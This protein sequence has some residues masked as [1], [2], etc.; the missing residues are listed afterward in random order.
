[1]SSLA[2]PL[3]HTLGADPPNPSPRLQFDQLT[4][5]DIAPLRNPSTGKFDIQWDATGN[6]L[7]DDTQEHA[8]LS[9]MLGRKAQ[10]WADQTGVRGSYLYVV[11][12]D[13]KA[14]PSKMQGYVVDALQPLIDNRTILAPQGQQTVAVTA[15]RVKPGRIDLA[16]T[17]TTPQGVTVTTRPALKY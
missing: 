7:F 17:Y 1:M 3:A 2:H 12:E 6:V 9:L 11:K 10:Y 14:T 16:V 5:S 8:V 13:R 15:T 4:G